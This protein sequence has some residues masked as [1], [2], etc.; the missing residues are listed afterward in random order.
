MNFTKRKNYTFDLDYSVRQNNKSIKY[1]SC[2]FSYL[3]ILLISIPN[4]LLEEGMSSN[5]LEQGGRTF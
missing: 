3:Y 2:I 4:S 1:K 5:C